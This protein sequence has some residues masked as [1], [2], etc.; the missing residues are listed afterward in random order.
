MSWKT[1][2]N[3]SEGYG[4][5]RSKDSR[6][7]K[8]KGQGASRMLKAFCLL[9][10]WRS[11]NGTSPGYESVFRKSTKALAEKR[12]RKKASTTVSLAPFTTVLMDNH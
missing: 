6:V 9:V 4:R 10:F 8:G 11:K 5:R 7:S 3:Q 2:H 1:K 12:Y